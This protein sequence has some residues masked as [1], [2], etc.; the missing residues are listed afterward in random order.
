VKPPTAL[1]EA[2]TLYLRGRYFA[3]KRTPEAL[4][5][6][7]EY[8]EQVIEL[9]PDYA[10][11]HAG[12]GECYTL[13][14]FEEFGNLAPCEAMPRAKRSLERAL[15]LDPEIAEGHN[16]RGAVAFLFEYDWPGAEAAFLRAINLRPA[17]ALAHTWYAVFLSAMSRH[18]EAIERIHHA[19]QL[20]PLAVTIHTVL[21][22]TY[23]L[24]RRFD[25]ALQR[26]LAILEMDPDNLRLQA[27]MA[28]VYNATG[29][30]ERGLRV[31]ETAIPRV[32]RRALLLVEQGR[33][34]AGLG[35]QE[36]A[37]RIIEELDDLRRREY[38][39][40]LFTASIHRAL[41]NKEEALGRFK[42]AVEQRSGHLPFLGVEP[43]WDPLR[44][45]PRF[46]ALVEKL[47]L[48]SS[49]SEGRTPSLAIR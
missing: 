48:P 26:Y 5:L 28:R 34:L 13:L 20:D 30:H 7:I 47:G 8:F 44:D 49:L 45:D 4:R 40:P 18:E 16:W 23:Y 21:A 46:Q 43:A 1:I 22:H 36:E 12:V 25:E 33:F 38:V 32:G 11:A 41:G 9:D 29:Q 27:W 39:P 14:G 35:R 10:L 2:Y 37:Y 24:A 17:Y 42:E 3:C 6:A 15:A 19:E 31:L